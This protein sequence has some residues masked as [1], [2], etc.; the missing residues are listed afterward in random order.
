MLSYYQK[1]AKSF[2][3]EEKSLENKVFDTL[4]NMLGE[5]Q[6][7]GGL[8]PGSIDHEEFINL[9]GTLPNA[10]SHPNTYAWYTLVSKFSAR[11][12]E[13]WAGKSTARGKIA[14]SE[15]LELDS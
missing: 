14:K 5:A 9:S 7:L 3:A 11:I 2:S 1:E 6:W 8:Q 15:I 4:E 12:R 10:I 13:S